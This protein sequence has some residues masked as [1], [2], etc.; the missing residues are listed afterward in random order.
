[1]KKLFMLRNRK[2]N[3]LVNV[4]NLLV[5]SVH[6][7]ADY[8]ET[9]QEATRVQDVLNNIQDEKTVK[10]SPGPDHRNYVED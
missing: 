1:M 5:N 3:G 10:V 2:T 4:I 8:Y 9:K 6:V 7:T